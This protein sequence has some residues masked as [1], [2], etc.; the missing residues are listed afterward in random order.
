[1][2]A[3]PFS[4]SL[5]SP[6]LALLALSALPWL[7]A[8]ADTLTE[9]DIAFAEAG[10]SDEKADAATELRVRVDGITTWFRPTLTTYMGEGWQVFGLDGR[11]SRNLSSV[12]SFV[13]ED[14]FGEASAVSAR[15]LHVDLADADVSQL[16]AGLGLRL[17][18]V[19]GTKTVH[20]RLQ[21]GAELGTF[22]GSS[23]LW[24]QRALAPVWVGGQVVYRT[25]VKAP[26]SLDTLAVRVGERAV[27]GVLAQGAGAFAGS[28]AS[29]SETDPSR[30]FAREFRVDFAFDDVAAAALPGGV[31]TFQ[32]RTASG[33]TLTKTASLSV[34]V[35]SAELTTDKPWE[36][37]PTDSCAPEVAACVR[38]TPG[39]GLGD[40]ATCGGARSVSLCVPS[41]CADLP[42]PTP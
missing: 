36:V 12:F 39:C 8:C 25:E 30:A 28:P 14:P 42:T 41:A 26:A 37:W 6:G 5:A 17:Q 3:L 24:I 27:A 40:T 31:I 1:M 9:P 29:G 19:A 21:V 22:A 35:A 32:G 2:R 7:P 23:K 4:G 38:A 20:A 18:I 10:P 15:K 34:R 11:T 13:P 16:L 33:A